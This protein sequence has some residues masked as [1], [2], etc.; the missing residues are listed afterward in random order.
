MGPTSDRPRRRAAGRRHRVVAATLLALAT[1]VPGARA[2][3]TPPGS[4]FDVAALHDPDAYPTR[5]A[6]DL[7]GVTSFFGTADTDELLPTLGIGRLDTVWATF[8]PE[9]VTPPCPAGHALYDGHCF[10]IDPAAEDTIRRFTEAGLPVMAITFGT[11]A[12][13]RTDKVCDPFNAWHDVFCSPDD[14]ADFAR[15]VGFLADRYDG[16]HGVGRITDFVVQN[17]VNLNQWFNIGCGKGI[18]CDLGAWVAEYAEL[19]NRA[20]DAIRAHQPRAKVLIPLTQHFEPSLDAPNATHPSYSVK[21][22][23]PP[24]VARLGDREWAIAH[25]PYPR[26]VDPRIDARDLPYATL[27]NVGVLSGWLRATFPDDPH[28]W[29]VELTEQGMNNPG[30]FDDLHVRSLC[31]AFRGVLGTPG[32]RSFIY[33]SLRDNPGEFGLSLGLHEQDGT[34]K[35]AL[36][37]WRDANDPDHPSCGFENLPDTV[38]RTG[39]DVDGRRWTSSRP[40]PRGYAM[41]DRQWRL[42]YE[43]APGTTLAYECGVGPD[44]VDPD[45]T[46]LWPEPD[47]DGAYPMGPVGWIAT[48]A[49]AGTTAV[50]TCGS[51][52][53]RTT[54]EGTCPAGPSR[55]V[56]HV[57]AEDTPPEALDLGD[58]PDLPTGPTTTTTTQPGPA[59][60]EHEVGFLLDQG[61]FRIGGLAPLD[62]PDGDPPAEGRTQLTG[63]WDEAT[64]ELRVTLRVPAFTAQVQTPLLPD[65]IP[66]TMH[67]TQVG[68]A[69]GSL[70]PSTGAMRLTIVLDTRL[71]SPDPLFAQF[72]GSTCTI[73]PATLELVTTAGFDLDA[74]DPVAT[75]TATGFTF[76]AAHGC[77]VGGDLDATLNPALGLPT[78][79]TEATMTLRFVRGGLDPDPDPEQTTTTLPG[80]PRPAAPGATPGP[81]E[82]GASR[83]PPRSRPAVAIRT[84]PHYTG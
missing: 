84:R 82:R 20:Y 34:P 78:D 1:L 47:C 46:F 77:G 56:G 50:S 9:V 41:Q 68:E 22:F 4:T 49:S 43:Q 44:P 57:A 74:T 12:W 29:E 51:G 54:V 3:T 36:A 67:V 30:L 28:A 79:D 73:G 39:V 53:G 48:A 11:P 42:R 19:Y 33:H 21:T 52:A 5:G 72:L 31:D 59:L 37:T 83:T 69:V 13:A 15:F 80:D 75:L 18:P 6:Y 26:S 25:H 38:V 70:D 24:V 55:V 14:P 35:P 32:I 17:E 66:T 7:K 76:P 8:E 27:G 23:L 64:G 60:G 71:T 2:D 10:R 65:P 16:T 81:G 45:A 61:R 58:P 63:T 40:L 62:L